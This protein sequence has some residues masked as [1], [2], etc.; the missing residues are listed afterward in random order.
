MNLAEPIQRMLSVPRS[1]SATMPIAWLRKEMIRFCP[2][3]TETRS[4]GVLIPLTITRAA[5]EQDFVP[6]RF[7]DMA[8]PVPQGS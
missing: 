7:Q 5:I 2:C 3:V 4:S 8:L 6:L 1:D